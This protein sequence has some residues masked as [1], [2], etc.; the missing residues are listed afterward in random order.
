MFCKSVSIF[1]SESVPPWRVPPWRVPHREVLSPPVTDTVH[2]TNN[3]V[4]VVCDTTSPGCYSHLL[5][6]GEWGRKAFGDLSLETPGSLP[7]ILWIPISPY[8]STEVTENVF[9]FRLRTPYTNSRCRLAFLQHL[10]HSPRLWQWSYAATRDGHQSLSV[11]G[12]LSDLFTISRPVHP[13]HCTSAQS[14]PHDGPELIP[15]QKFPL[16]GYQFD[17]VSFQVTSNPGSIL[18]NQA[19][20]CSFLLSHLRRMCSY[21]ADPDRSLCV[22][23]ENGSSGTAY[24]YLFSLR[25]R[26]ISNGGN[27]HTMFWGEPQLPVQTRHWVV[28]RCIEHRL[29]ST[30][31]CI[32]GVRCMD[33]NR[34]NTSHQCTRVRS[35]TQSNAP[36]AAEAYGSDSPGCVRKLHCSV[37][38]QQAQ[39]NKVNTAVQAD[40][41]VTP[42]VRPT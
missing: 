33:N 41:E 23:R 40:Q 8:P 17:L 18:Q 29:G 22:H 28:H 12:R 1:S 7:P 42:R 6:D 5:L 15:K 39:L 36:L 24:G 20:I 34:E 14:L 13:R 27:Q 31:E 21:V 35:H 3:I 4:E 30:M 32:D 10:G 2:A 25:R 38:H 19:L 26:K 11:P 37:L 9:D 16:L